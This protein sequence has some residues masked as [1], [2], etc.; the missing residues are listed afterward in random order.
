VAAEA[1]ARDPG[2]VSAAVARVFQEAGVQAARVD[3]GAAEAQVQAAQ[4]VPGKAEPAELARVVPAVEVVPQSMR[5]ICG[6]RRDRLAVVVAAVAVVEA[7]ELRESGVVVEEAEL[8]L[9]GAAEAVL[10]EAVEPV[11]AEAVEPALV[12]VAEPVLEVAAVL[13]ATLVALPAR[14]ARR[15]RR[16]ENG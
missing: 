12:E 8:V 10:V 6:G 14:E 13:Q 9:A 5:V 7:E 16:L 1:A 11:A 3:P 15:E 2:S 4:A